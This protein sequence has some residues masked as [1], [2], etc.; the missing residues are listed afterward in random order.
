MAQKQ[1][2]QNGSQKPHLRLLN[3]AR[4]HKVLTFIVAIPLTLLAFNILGDQLQTFNAYHQVQISRQEKLLK[5]D[6]TFEEQKKLISELGGGTTSVA[7][8]K[9]DI[10][11]IAHNDSGWMATDYYQECYIRYVQLFTT[12]LTK[13]EI[14]QKLQSNTQRANLSTKTVV[15]SLFG[16]VEPSSYAT[17]KY[18]QCVVY[19]Q[20]YS[21]SVVYIPAGF[22][23]SKYEFPQDCEAPSKTDV[24][25]PAYAMADLSVK[26]YQDIDPS[27]VDTSKIQLWTIYT[28]KYYEENLGCGV[29][30]LFCE[31]PRSKPAHPEI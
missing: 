9:K 3:F 8:S 13:D 15:N 28:S 31:S 29:G 26:T 11:F 6:K 2:T 22:D 14:I 20:N 30:I 18:A 25:G 24:P 12:D 21:P 5:S 4:R 19:K 10:C 16:D 7:L 17:E 23:A 27:L 1:Q